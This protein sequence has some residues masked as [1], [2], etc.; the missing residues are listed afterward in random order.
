MA[1]SYVG[2]KAFPILFQVESLNSQFPSHCT[3]HVLTC[4]IFMQF[5]V[6]DIDRGAALSFLSEYPGEDEI[7]IPPL[8]YLEV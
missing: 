4:E 6:G 5:E 1:K 3:S 2:G 8:S 7:L